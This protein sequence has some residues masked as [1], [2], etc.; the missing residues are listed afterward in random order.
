MDF[1]GERG[2]SNGGLL[3]LG[4]EEG[5]VGFS[6]FFPVQSLLFSFLCPPLFSVFKTLFIFLRHT[7]FPSCLCFP[8]RVVREFFLTDEVGTQERSGLCI[9]SFCGEWN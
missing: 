6:F 8:Y 2:C 5:S 3:W 7:P 4:E 9:L 1:G